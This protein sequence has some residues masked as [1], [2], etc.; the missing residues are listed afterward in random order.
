MP[1][2][3]KYGGRVKGTPNK[4]TVEVKAAL[5]EAFD[6]LGGVESLV[7]WGKSRRDLF[8]AMWVKLLPKNIN[9]KGSL[10]L[11]DLVAGSNE[12]GGGTDD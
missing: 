2:G 8:Y 9:V 10:T 7:A 4:T 5:E 1:K 3:R 12:N 6:K 11:E